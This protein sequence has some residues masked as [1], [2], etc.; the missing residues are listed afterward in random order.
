LKRKRIK[1]VKDLKNIKT[2]NNG[3]YQ[4]KIERNA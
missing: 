2:N 4:I 1:K 3:K